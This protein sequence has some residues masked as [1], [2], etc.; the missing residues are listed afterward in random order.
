MAV[1]VARRESFGNFGMQQSML[2][3]PEDRPDWGV[4]KGERERSFC[5]FQIHEPAHGDTA[6]R[7]G[8]EDYKTNVESCVKM[9]RVIYDNAG[10]FHP[11]TEYHKIIAMR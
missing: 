10:G 1:E 4:K 11:W 6:K 9:A 3:Y 8:L 2:R 7:L 5:F